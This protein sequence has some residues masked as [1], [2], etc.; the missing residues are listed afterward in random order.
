ADRATGGVNDALADALGLRDVRPLVPVAPP[1]L[2]KL[3]VFAPRA[4]TDSMIAALSAAGAGTIGNY[5]EAAFVSQGVGRFRPLAGAHP[6]VGRV[7]ETERVDEAR[8]EMVV[9]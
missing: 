3:V 1:G 8:I 5:D 7:G 6:A 4:E 2:E 9:P